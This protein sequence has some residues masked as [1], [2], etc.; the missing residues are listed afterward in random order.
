MGS[1]GNMQT[2]RDEKGNEYL[3]LKR[4]EESSRVHD[5]ETDEERYFDNERLEPVAGESPLV[6]AASAVPKSVRRVMSAV[7]REEALGL[8]LEID[9]RGPISVRNLLSRY[10]LCESDL[11]GLCTEF[12][13]AGLTS[14]T[15]VA[16]ERGYRTTELASD[17]LE[18]LRET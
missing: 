13:A 4:S 15:E 6:T 7:S 17:A 8:L 10:D 9:T 16:G 3:L 14:E 12:R 1:R 11:H 5:P 2:V 18:R